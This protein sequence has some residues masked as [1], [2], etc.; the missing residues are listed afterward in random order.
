MPVTSKPPRW[1]TGFSLIELMVGVVIGAW[2]ILVLM[3]VLGGFEGDKRGTTGGADAQ[4]NGA[5]ALDGL[6]RDIR[7]GGYGISWPTLF[8]CNMTLPSG[9][10]VPVA[11]VIINP[12]TSIIPAG[13]ANTDTLLVIYG[14]TNGEPQGNEITA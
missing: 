11:P 3:G 14:N 2:T 10:T 1:M 13:D 8:T 6:Q 9:G 5:L 12:A 7:Q 4:N